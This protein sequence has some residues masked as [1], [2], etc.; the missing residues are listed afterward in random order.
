MASKGR[1]TGGVAGGRVTRKAGKNGS[2][3]IM[4]RKTEGEKK[5]ARVG[6][7]W[8]L[9]AVLLVDAAVVGVGVY[10]IWNSPLVTAAKSAMRA[11]T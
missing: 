10:E 6:H 3:E 5:P 8:L 9:V 11:V 1:G 2:V 4:Y 7:A